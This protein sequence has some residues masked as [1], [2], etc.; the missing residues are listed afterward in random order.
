MDNM[1]DYNGYK[2]TVEFSLKDQVFYGQIFGIN[3]TVMYEG[4][5]V[6]ELQKM[7]REAVD[8]YL[9]TCKEMGKEPERAFKGSFNIRI[10]PELHRLAALKAVAAKMSLNEFVENAIAG[11]LKSVGSKAIGGLFA[12]Q[13]KGQKR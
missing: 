2:G 1:L 3:D 5:S 8:D 13:I 7:F 4:S 12:K 9:E 11:S 10:N 6:K